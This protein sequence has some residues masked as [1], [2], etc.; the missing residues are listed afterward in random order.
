MNTKRILALLLTVLSAFLCVSAF[1]CGGEEDEPVAVYYTVTFDYG[2]GSGAETFRRVEYGAEI[3]NL[4]SPSEIPTGAIFTGWRTED[5][6]IFAENT[7]YS[8]EGNITLT[9]NYGYEIYTITYNVAGG[10]TLPSDAPTSYTVIDADITLPTPT[11]TGFMFLG[12]QESETPDV[13]VTVIP[14][15][16][17]GNKSFIAVWQSQF[18]I[19]LNNSTDANFT[20]WADGTVGNKTVLVNV[21]ETL[22]IPAIKWDSYSSYA[23]ESADYSFIGWFYKDKNN[24]ERKLDASTVF[25]F[26]NLNIDAY[27]LTVYAKV[28]GYLWVGPY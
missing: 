26:E 25:S 27:Q 22:T 4:P 24:T 12:W 14:E 6:R 9:A 2:E 1:G 5:G 20:A 19:T 21:G 15:G 16:S 11:K 10:D 3:K 23:K 18:V 7:K 13:Y 28:S 8:F 17:T